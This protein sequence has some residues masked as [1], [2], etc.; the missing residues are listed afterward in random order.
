MQS[1]RYSCQNLTKVWFSRRIFEKSSNANSESLPSGSLV[2]PCGRTDEQTDM[3]M[4]QKM[5]H[6]FLRYFASASACSLIKKRE[7]GG[8]H[9]FSV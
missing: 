5:E 4:R 9:E 6:I 1:T 3:R 8:C 7:F 2:V